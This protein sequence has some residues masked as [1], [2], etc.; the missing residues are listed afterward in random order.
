MSH[1]AEVVKAL[2]ARARGKKASPPLVSTPKKENPLI[3]LSRDLVARM[4]AGKEA[5]L[6]LKAVRDWKGSEAIQ[7]AHGDLASYHAVLV[8][9]HEAGQLK[10]KG[11]N[12]MNTEKVDG[13]EYGLSM[14]EKW[15]KA[16][17]PGTFTAFLD[18]ERKRESEEGKERTKA[19]GGGR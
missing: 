15:N 12:F 2:Q 3:P 6:A 9:L 8:E 7:R 1:I 5:L 4:P 13:Q 17:R 11:E 10:L 19:A 16:G 18:A 14:Y